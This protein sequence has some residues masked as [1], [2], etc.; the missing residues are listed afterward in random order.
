[1]EN[2]K[3]SHKYKRNYPGFIKHITY[4]IATIIY[5]LV[6]LNPGWMQVFIPKSDHE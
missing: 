3:I 5:Q 2:K 4:I 6:I 1:M